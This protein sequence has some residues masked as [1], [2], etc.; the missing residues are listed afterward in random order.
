M[1]YL[2]PVTLILVGLPLLLWAW[3]GVYRSFCEAGPPVAR[4]VDALHVALWGGVGML[5]SGVGI[6]FT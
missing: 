4:K 2:L 3:A 5:G 1:S 6:L